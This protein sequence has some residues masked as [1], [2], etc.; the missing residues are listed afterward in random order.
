MTH[1]SLFTSKVQENRR[2]RK[3]SRNDK[4]ETKKWKEE[5]RNGEIKEEKKWYQNIYK[6]MIEGI[7][8]KW[9]NLKGKTK[10]GDVYIYRWNYLK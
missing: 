7:G 8:E 3:E 4:E 9:I 6:G 2:K 1:L 10:Y 5:W